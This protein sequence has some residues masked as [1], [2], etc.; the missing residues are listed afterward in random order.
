MAFSLRLIRLVDLP[1]I[2]LGVLAPIVLYLILVHP[3]T[4]SNRNSVPDTEIIAWQCSGVTDENWREPHWDV[5]DSEGIVWS[6][7]DRCESLIG[8]N[9]TSLPCSF[10]NLPY[11]CHEDP[12]GNI[13]VRNHIGFATV[14]LFDYARREHV[15]DHLVIHYPTYPPPGG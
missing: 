4:D 14:F 9:P 2:V 1:P 10:G 15:G 11:Y 8:N 13:T 12:N 5:V 7:Q 6:S 3:N